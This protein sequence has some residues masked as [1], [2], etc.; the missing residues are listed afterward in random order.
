MFSFFL[1]NNDVTNIIKLIFDFDD[2]ISETSGFV[3]FSMIDF[4]DSFDMLI[5]N[6]M[7]EKII[8]IIEN[9]EK[10]EK[11]NNNVEIKVDIRIIHVICLKTYLK[12]NPSIFLLLRSLEKLI[13][14]TNISSLLKTVNKEQIKSLSNVVGVYFYS[15][16]PF[17]YFPSV[18]SLMLNYLIMKNINDEKK[19]FISKIE[20]LLL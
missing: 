15:L 3:I 20:L 2:L 13:R 1:F 4:D 10:K 8:S 12:D 7:I 17:L 16:D 18:I 5:K 11:T 9:E 19:K 6:Q 14:F